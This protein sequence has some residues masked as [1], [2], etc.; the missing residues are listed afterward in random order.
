[1]LAW[2]GRACRLVRGT[3]LRQSR[4][5]QSRHSLPVASRSPHARCMCAGPGSNDESID[6]IWIG[7]AALNQG[8]PISSIMAA[9][10]SHGVAD[11]CITRG[12]FTVRSLSEVGSAL[13]DHLSIP[14]S[15]PATIPLIPGTR[16]QPGAPVRRFQAAGN[17]QLG[18][19]VRVSESNCCVARARH[20]PRLTIFSVYDA[21]HCRTLR[22][23]RPPPTRCTA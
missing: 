16:C 18:G 11:A 17:H 20:S 2:G 3:P 13:C 15:F 1:M 21:V 23:R 4:R 5:S 9:F 7:L 8:A 14:G 12:E 22:R 10:H 6:Q 19:G